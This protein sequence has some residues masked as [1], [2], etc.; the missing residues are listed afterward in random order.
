MIEAQNQLKSLNDELELRVKN[1]TIELSDTL[2]KLT[3]TQAQL[4]ES[5]KMASL[6]NL[7]TG[8][9]HELNTPLGVILTATSQ[10]EHKQK[11]LSEK[12]SQQTLSSQLL[13]AYNNQSNACIA[14]INSSI[15]KSINLVE[16]FKALS[17]SSQNEAIKTIE[18][19]LLFENIVK[20]CSIRAT[21]KAAFITIHCPKQLNIVSYPQIIKE[22]FNQLVE[23]SCLHAFEDIL[24]N[25]VEIEITIT[26]K[27]DEVHLLYQD[28]G[29]GLSDDLVGNIFDPF[30]TTKRGSDCIGLGMPI[31]Y[32]QVVHSL[33]GSIKLASSISAGIEIII[34]LPKKLSP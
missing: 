9:A 32:N 11:Q 1:R 5:E 28:N 18:L 8:V 15:K 7:V 16:N 23:N 6:V 19:P 4:L 3:A 2:E 14:L 24:V 12:I 33:L 17:Y 27:T 31:V 10:L 34:V 29:E 20:D 26:D 21:T 13:A 30:S 22:V 25:Q